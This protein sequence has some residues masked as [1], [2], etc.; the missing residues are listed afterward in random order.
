MAFAHSRLEARRSL[1]ARLGDAPMLLLLLIWFIAG[2]SLRV[3]AGL[4]LR[5][6]PEGRQHTEKIEA[7][8]LSGTPIMLPVSPLLPE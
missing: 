4:W 2:Y 1:L 3:I 7:Y 5:G 8:C 6:W